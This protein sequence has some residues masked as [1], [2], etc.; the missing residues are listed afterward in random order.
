MLG[1]LIPFSAEGYVHLSSNEQSRTYVPGF[2]GIYAKDVKYPS[3]GG[4]PFRLA[5]SSSSF[6]NEKAGPVIGVF[7]YEVSDDYVPSDNTR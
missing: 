5:Y 1:N 6:D 4:G 2:A 7:V 3:D